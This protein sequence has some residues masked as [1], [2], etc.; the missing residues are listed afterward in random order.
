MRIALATLAVD[1]KLA[2]LDRIEATG[3]RKR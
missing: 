2:K 3:K 1:V